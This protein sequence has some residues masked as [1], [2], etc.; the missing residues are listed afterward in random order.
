[1]TGRR[2]DG[3]RKPWLSW[4]KKLN[5]AV[6]VLVLCL[7]PIMIGVGSFMINADEELARSG[8]QATGTIV[9]F[10]DVTKASERRMQVEFPAA[11]RV[12][13]RTFAAVDHDQHPVVGSSVTVIYA[14]NDPGRAIVPGYESE[15]VW[16]RGVGVVLT[17]IFGILGLL[18]LALIGSAV[19]RAKLRR[20]RTQQVV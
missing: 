13:H 15:G 12:V 7:G 17:V 1:M 20:R 6:T 4:K 18:L 16:V 2:I 8:V 11:D 3:N 5:L 19:L 14:E 10:N 9:H